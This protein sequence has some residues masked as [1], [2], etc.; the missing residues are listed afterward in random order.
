M[1][2]VTLAPML[3]LVAVA[4]GS[5]GSPGAADDPATVTTRPAGQDGDSGSGEPT[6]QTD[7]VPGEEPDGEP[8]GLAADDAYL[9]VVGE[10]YAKTFDVSIEEAK[11]RLIRQD[12]L[13][14]LMQEIGAVEEGRIAGRGIVHEPV[15]GGWVYLVGDEP[16][17]ATTAA[18]QRANDDKIGRA[19]CRERV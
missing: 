4:C 14:P 8:T 2:L 18:I 19:S 5:S 9:E 11:R 17:T 6:E 16:P 15:F 7:G 10:Q 1:K 12:E 13:S 3:L